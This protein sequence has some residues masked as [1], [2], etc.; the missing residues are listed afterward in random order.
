MEFLRGFHPRI[1]PPA[2]QMSSRVEGAPASWAGVAHKACFFDSTK[3]R[4]PMSTIQEIKAAIEALAPA[5]RTELA[6]WLHGHGELVD[7]KR[8][9]LPDYAARRRR[10]FG[11]RILPN[12]VLEAR[13]LERY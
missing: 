13:E 1:M 6:H 10:I 3:Y 9:P 11:R 7:E 5:Q 4:F 2:A 12:A 8:L